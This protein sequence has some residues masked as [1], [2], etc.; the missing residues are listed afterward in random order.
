MRKPIEREGFNNSR[1][2]KNNR[3]DFDKLSSGDQLQNGLDFYGKQQQA[4]QSHH[5]QDNN[6]ERIQM[7]KEDGGAQI[8]TELPISQNK[9]FN[10]KNFKNEI[11]DREEVE[12]QQNSAKLST[13]VMD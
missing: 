8:V 12:S 11:Y 4:V 7:P 3:G 9:V 5:S 13:S 6:E 1:A 10:L 2:D